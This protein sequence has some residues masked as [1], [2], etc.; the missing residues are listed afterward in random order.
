MKTASRFLLR[1]TLLASI[2]AATH[3]SANN[4]RIGGIRLQGIDR[5]AGTADILV[6]VAWDN[7][8]RGTWDGVEQWDAAW[9]FAKVRTAPDAPWSHVWLSTADGACAAPSGAALSVGTTEISGV[10]RG[11]GAFLYAASDEAGGVEYPGVRLRWEFGAQGVAL[12]EDSSIEVSV[13]GIEM[14]RVAPGAFWAGNTGGVANDSFR[15]A[16]DE[17]AAVLV[18]SEDAMTLCHGADPAEGDPAS[19]AIPAAFPKGVNGFY[20]MKY[21]VTQG[22]WADFLNL[23]TRSQQE[24]VCAARTAGRYMRDNDNSTTPQNWN[25][26]HVVDDLAGTSLPRVYAATYPDLCCNWLSYDD[27]ALWASWA[28]LRPMTELEYEKACRGPLAPVENEY[29]WGDT[30]FA[31][32]SEWSPSKVHTGRETINN[33]AANAVAGTNPGFMPR[34]GIFATETADAN[35]NQRTRT[36][37][38]AAYFGAMEMGS[39]LSELVI[40]AGNASGLAFTGTHGAGAW[41]LPATW[42]ATTYWGNAAGLGRRGGNFNDDKAKARICDRTSAGAGGS[43]LQTVGFRAVRTEP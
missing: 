28:G 9:L 18:S 1:A 29:V 34:A 16:S 14:V 26:V 40:V 8:W 5:A 21:M 39:V 27:V 12:A 43:R 37:S 23:I 2:L 30:T 24:R 4:L 42:P 19:Y 20:C 36:L 7:S 32:S 6:N 3:V 15:D 10:P 17:T 13:M 11:I 35:R 33:S 22:Q 41:G 25:Y 31:N 38:G